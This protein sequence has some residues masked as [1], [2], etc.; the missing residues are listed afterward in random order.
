[1]SDTN[2]LATIDEMKE[3]ELFHSGSKVSAFLPEE[4]S[5]ISNYSSFPIYRL[6][7]SEVNWGKSVS[8]VLNNPNA[9]YI[10]DIHLE[11]TL[12]KI[13]LDPAVVM[14]YTKAEGIDANRLGLD[15]IKNQEEL[16]GWIYPNYVRDLESRQRANMVIDRQEFARMIIPLGRNEPLDKSRITAAQLELLEDYIKKRY[17]KPGNV[18]RVR[19]IDNVGHYIMKSAKLIVDDIEYFSIDPFY[20]DIKRHFESGEIPICES[21]KIFLKKNKKILLLSFM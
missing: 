4:P 19:W 9:D 21:I 17:F 8:F 6:P 13:D 12:P 7:D 15:D 18:Y 16:L 10:T 14:G 2:V 3:N 5:N 20:M 1:M 11:F